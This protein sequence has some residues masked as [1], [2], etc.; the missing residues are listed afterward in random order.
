MHAR[1]LCGFNG[2]QRAAALGLAGAAVLGAGCIK[3]PIAD[4]FKRLTVDVDVRPFLRAEDLSRSYETPAGLP[5]ATIRLT[6]VAVE[7]RQISRGSGRVEEVTVDVALRYDNRSGR[8]RAR[9][10][11]YFAASLDSTYDAPP[12]TM[13]ETTLADSSLSVGQARFQAD[14]RLLDLFARQQMWMG[15]ELGLVPESGQGLRGRYTIETLTAHV[16]S[17]VN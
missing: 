10:G 3:N 15:V 17:R 12:V 4:A 14:A 9:F 7:L 13:I 5:D 16:V 2:L 11:L 6:P 8:G 1:K